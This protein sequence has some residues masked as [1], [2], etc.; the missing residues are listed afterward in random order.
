LPNHLRRIKSAFLM[1]TAWNVW[2]ERNRR[3]FEGR[4]KDAMQVE[5][6]IKAEMALRRMACGG[7]ELP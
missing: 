4:Q 5:Q 7:P 6:Q 3:I 2:E 1:Y